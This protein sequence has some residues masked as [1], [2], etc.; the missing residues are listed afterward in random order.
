MV[1]IT[2]DGPAVNLAMLKKL[3]ASV[4]PQ[5]IQSEIHFR[6]ADKPV[7]ILIDNCHCLKNVRNAFADLNVI[8]DSE[9][10]KIEW[11]F[12]QQ[13]L[14]VQTSETFHLGNKITRDHV[15][16]HNQKMKVKLATQ[17]FS[18]STANAIDHCRDDLKI[19]EFQCSNA[20][21]K[22]LRTFDEIFDLL[23]SKSKYSTWSKAPLSETN[24]G[25]WKDVFDS[26]A[27]YILSLTEQCGKRLVDGRRRTGFLGFLLN[28]VSTESIFNAYVVSGPLEYI[29]TYKLSQDHLEIFF[30]CIRARLGSNN[31]PTVIQE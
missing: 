30:G 18:R 10:R 11:K 9:G 26:A 4:D 13:L 12:I 7:N 16:F 25:Y 24:T 21:T 6:S 23:N 15:Y 20:T 5:G 29:L 19:P 2:F 28:M 31:N 8:L 27:R 14:E 17:V 3:G 1:S 22:F